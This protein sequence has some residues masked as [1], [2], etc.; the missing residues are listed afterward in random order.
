MKNA[1]HNGRNLTLIAPRRMGK[2][3]LIKNVFYKL[4]EEQPDI[5][6]SIWIPI[7]GRA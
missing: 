4:K 6:H 7:R 1:L 2:T 3:G 5:V